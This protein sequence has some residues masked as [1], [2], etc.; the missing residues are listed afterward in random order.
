VLVHC[1]GDEPVNQSG[2]NHGTMPGQQ[3]A[4]PNAEP[5]ESG[6]DSAERDDSMPAEYPAEV[7]EKPF[8]D[9]WYPL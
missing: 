5:A 7:A 3:V 4:K 1:G 8:E 6:P 2:V 9:G